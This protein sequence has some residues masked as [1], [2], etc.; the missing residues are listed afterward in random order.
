MSD[1]LM[2]NRQKH[3]HLVTWKPTTGTLVHFGHG[4]TYTVATAVTQEHQT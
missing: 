2:G 3:V 1:L 4:E